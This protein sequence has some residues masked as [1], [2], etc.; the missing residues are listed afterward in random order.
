MHE[1]PK[2]TMNTNNFHQI[3]PRSSNNNS[4][5]PA[6]ESTDTRELAI[7]MQLQDHSWGKA[8]ADAMACP[9]YQELVQTIASARRTGL[10]IYPPTEQVFAAFDKTP[11]AR[12]QVVILGQD[13]YHGPGQAHGLAFSVG[14]TTR[15]PP[16]LRNIFK[17]YCSDLGFDMPKHGNLSLWA[18]RGVL[19]LNTVLTVE[20]GRPASHAK[21]GWEQI[22]AKAVQAVARERQHV[23]FVLWG[24]KAQAHAQH[25]DPTK[26]LIIR[27]PHPSPLSAH[28]GFFGSRPFTQINQYRINLGLDP[29][30]WQLDS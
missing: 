28:R 10:K 24:D 26:H 1:T 16:S 4:K 23:A 27:A 21:R 8:L 3:T 20:D 13:P 18:E 11:L 17:E 19:L 14:V 7:N 12:V 22:T 29:I 5:P 6:P 9:Q 25:I 2:S 15:L 30:N